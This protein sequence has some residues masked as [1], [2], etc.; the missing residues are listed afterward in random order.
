MNKRCFP[1]LGSCAIDYKM[2]AGGVW[3][4]VE[5]KIISEIASEYD[6]EKQLGKKRIS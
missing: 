4:K 1:L 3:Q 5:N 2:I 6:T